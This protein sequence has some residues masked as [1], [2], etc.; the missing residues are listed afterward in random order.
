MLVE[1]LD[2]Y[3]ESEPRLEEGPFLD[4]NDRQLLERIA[5]GS[6]IGGVDVILLDDRLER[7]L[8]DPAEDLPEADADKRAELADAYSNALND[9]V[10]CK[11][12]GVYTSRGQ[13]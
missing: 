1:A 3:I 11:A 2:L 10:R 9:Y 4:H 7:I 13:F 8:H 6:S 12:G 5:E